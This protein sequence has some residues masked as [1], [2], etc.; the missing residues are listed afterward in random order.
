[1]GRVRMQKRLI[2][3]TGYKFSKICWLVSPCLLLDLSN[4]T[5]VFVFLHK[6]INKY[7]PEL[8]RIKVF[9]TLRQVI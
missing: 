6:Q 2:K 9:Q 3:T 4:E 5:K 7:L 8:R 1:M